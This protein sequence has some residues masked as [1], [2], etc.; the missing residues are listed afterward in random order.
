MKKISKL[1]LLLFLIYWLPF[2]FILS[3]YKPYKN[4]HSLPYADAVIVFGTL[5]KNNI[6]SP[7]LKERLDTSIHIYHAHK[8]KKIVVSNTRRASLVMHQYLVNNN[9]PSK[10][11]TLDV[12]AI[13]TPDTCKYE[14]KQ[15]PKT[16]KL[17]FVS[18]GYHL[19]RTNYQCQ[20][21]GIHAS[22]FP[23]EQLEKNR[24][25]IFSSIKVF[26]IR[27]KRY[28]REA[29]LTFLAVLNIYT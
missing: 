1:F 10:D 4:I 13:K 28:F 12:T 18:Q 5:V 11:I 3:Y 15:F 27:T 8:A 17:I 6:V 19:P 23:A 24:A 29:G 14:K 2:I 25:K 7:L 26:T 21:L 16:R 22:L 9:I 20:K